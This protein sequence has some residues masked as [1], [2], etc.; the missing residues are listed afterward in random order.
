MVKLYLYGLQRSGTNAISN[1]LNINYNVNL[2]NSSDRG[3]IS[4]KHCRIYDNKIHI[5]SPEQYYNTFSINKLEDLDNLLGDN[6]NTNIYIVIYKDIFSWLPSI[7]KWAKNCNWE[8]NDKMDFV[9][10]YLNYMDKWNKIKNERVLL[11]N[12]N[13]YLELIINKNNAIIRKLEEFL[14]VKNEK[15]IIIPTKVAQSEE[16]TNIKIDYYK[17]KKYMNIFSEKEIL[18]IKNNHLFINLNN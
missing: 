10:D 12:Y 2:C 18:L 16:F 9:E 7:S 13:E 6:K 17:N 15:E 3:S 1:F 11:I 14:H 8:K 5:P 4:H